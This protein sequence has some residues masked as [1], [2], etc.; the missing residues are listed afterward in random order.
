M[1]NFRLSRVLRAASITCRARCAKASLVHADDARLAAASRARAP[2]TRLVERYRDRACIVAWQ[3]EHEA[4]DPLGLEHSW[5]L[6]R[7]LC[8]GGNRGGQSAPDPTRPVLMNGFLPMSIPVRLQQWWR[9]RDQGD[10]LAFAQRPADI[11]GAGLLP[12]ARAG[13]SRAADGVSRR[14]RAPCPAPAAIAPVRDGANGTRPQLM[15]SEGQAEPWE[16]VVDAARPA[17][18]A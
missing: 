11:V 15:I 14:R 18:R 7:R 13:Q 12:A 2:R 8:P 3:V 1:K 17:R 5:R 10:S 4:V 6:A 16:T 9:T